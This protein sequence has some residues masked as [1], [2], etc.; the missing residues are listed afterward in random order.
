MLR[1]LD[2]IPIRSRK[3]VTEDFFFF[4]LGLHMRHID[5]PRLGV[6]SEL[7]LPVCATA[8]VKPDPSLVFD[9]HHSSR[10]CRIFNP[11]KQVRD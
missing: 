9:V 1:G 2:L 11:L 4:F 5:V 7:W 8:T 6:E 10:Q 3:V